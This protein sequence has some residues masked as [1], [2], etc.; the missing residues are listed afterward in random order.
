MGIRNFILIGSSAIRTG[1][2][3]A[4][5]NSDKRHKKTIIT[6]LIKIR[7]KKRITVIMITIKLIF[8][9]FI[10]EKLI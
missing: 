10:I 8:F 4:I 2:V 9:E 6:Y 1:Y 5:T 3:L 7:P